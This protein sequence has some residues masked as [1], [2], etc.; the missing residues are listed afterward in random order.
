ML[1]CTYAL[2]L[3]SIAHAQLSTIVPSEIIRVSELSDGQPEVPILT[4]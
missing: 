1:L 2:N 3:I 4:M